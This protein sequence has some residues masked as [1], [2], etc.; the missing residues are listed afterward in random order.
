MTFKTQSTYD[1]PEKKK[2]KSKSKGLLSPDRVVG[3]IEGGLKGAATGNPWVTAGSA[4]LG[5]LK[6]GAPNIDGRSD[7][8]KRR[9]AAAKK[10]KAAIMSKKIPSLGKG[11]T[12]G[13]VSEEADE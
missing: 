2:S 10:K 4:A 3:A 5:Y 8:D 7:A 1:L 11:S 12:E 6:G 13:E 9:M